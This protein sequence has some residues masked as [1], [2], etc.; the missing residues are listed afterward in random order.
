M[1]DCED[2][3]QKASAEGRSTLY[4]NEAQQICRLH[5]ISTP[6]SYL[7]SNLQEAALKAKRIGFPVV[8]KIVS[9][10][11][12]HKSDV[13]GVIL[14]VRSESELKVQYKKMTAD[15]SNKVP[16]AK[17]LGVSVEKMMPSSTEFIVGAL[18]DAQ[19][20][21]TIMFGVGGIFT[22][23]YND[24]AFRVAPIDKIDAWNLIHSLNGSRI[25]E[26][27]RGNRRINP[28]AIIN[29]LLKVSE[30]ITEHNSINQIDLNPVMAYP[31]AVC[32]VDTRIIVK[33]K[34]GGI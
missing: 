21:P 10:Q 26:G 18:R 1:R 16:S 14:N 15:V 12:I 25:L 32:A 4:P 28:E 22:E 34:K 20:G 11:I 7:V 31:D 8:L 33:P 27:V 9:P 19:F 5:C 3:L 13:G 6:K 24:V 30:L 17:I 23:I 29:L 2:I